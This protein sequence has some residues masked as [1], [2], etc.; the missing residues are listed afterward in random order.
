MTYGSFH[1]LQ[2]I[3]IFVFFKEINI[4]INQ[5]ITIIKKWQ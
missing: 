4:F 2:C 1:F 3:N 5:S